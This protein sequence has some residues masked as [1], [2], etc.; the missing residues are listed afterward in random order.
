MNIRGHNH[1]VTEMQA[2]NY[3]LRYEPFNKVKGHIVNLERLASQAIKL[4]LRAAKSDIEQIRLEFAELMPSLEG[5]RIPKQFISQVAK[6]CRDTFRSH[7]RVTIDIAVRHADLHKS[8][9]TWIENPNKER[10]QLIYE[11]LIKLDI[12]IRR[13]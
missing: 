10:L 7:E 3:Y 13:L 4:N 6:V 9:D 11:D 8:Y 5:S 2:S 12:S 1:L